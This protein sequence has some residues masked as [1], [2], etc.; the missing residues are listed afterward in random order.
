MVYD[1]VCVTC[2]ARPKMDGCDC[3]EE[4]WYSGAYSEQQALQRM[5]PRRRAAHFADLAFENQRFHR[6]FRA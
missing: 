5:T 4:C 3:C 2:R 1:P 6:S